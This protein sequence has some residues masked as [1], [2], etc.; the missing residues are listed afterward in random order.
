MTTAMK[1]IQKVKPMPTE[2][3]G[4][5]LLIVTADAETGEVTRQKCYPPT[6]AGLR[7]F[8]RDVPQRRREAEAGGQE[9]R[10]YTVTILYTVGTPDQSA[11]PL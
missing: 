3:P 5:H 1:P 4:R 10:E 7:Y 9:V 2:L 8:L 6:V 11:L